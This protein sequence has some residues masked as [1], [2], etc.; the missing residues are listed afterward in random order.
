MLQQ[1]QIS[2]ILQ[3]G[4]TPITLNSKSNSQS[5]TTIPTS[6]HSI[7]SISLLSKQGIPLITVSSTTDSGSGIID[8]DYKIY[9]I[10]AYNSL[11]KPNENDNDNDNDNSK[12]TNKLK[13]KE[14]ETWTIIQFEP[15]LKCMIER[16]L[17]MYLVLYYDGR[18]DNKDRDAGTDNKNNKLEGAANGDAVNVKTKETRQLEVEVDAFVKL[19]MDGLVLSLHDGLLGYNNE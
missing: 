3:Q 1:K 9:S 8:Q 7:K 5:A 17:D 10:I 16:C 19:K 12:N 4:L 13:S 11:N 14:N 6:T 15:G 2:K 18:V